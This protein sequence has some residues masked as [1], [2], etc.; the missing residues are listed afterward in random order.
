MLWVYCE[1]TDKKKG[2]RGGERKAKIE[3]REKVIPMHSSGP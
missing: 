3:G 2:N 1:D